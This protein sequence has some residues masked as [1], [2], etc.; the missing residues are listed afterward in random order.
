MVFREIRHHKH[1]QTEQ[2]KVGVLKR[3]HMGGRLGN[4]LFSWAFAHQLPLCEE[5][6]LL[7]SQSIDP[8]LSQLLHKCT[9]VEIG[10]ISPLV[11]FKL[12]L[13]FKLSN[14]F[15]IMKLFISKAFR[16]SCEPDLLNISN[17]KDYCG[18]FQMY[19][20]VKNS[21]EIIF[22]ELMASVQQIDLPTSFLEWQNGRRYQCWHIRRGDYLLPENSGYGLLSLEWYLKHK[23]L[24]MRTV[25][26]TD[27]KASALKLLK[28]DDNYLILGP[29]D[30]NVFQA[31]AIMSKSSH[32]VAANSTLSWW[33]GFLVATQGHSVIYPTS[34][35]EKH[36]DINSPL[37]DL[38][39]G[40][41]D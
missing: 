30:A 11:R 16:V 5:S 41:Y 14:K 2:P 3:I 35:V 38:K 24:N 39:P 21:Q 23:N 22:K 40:V 4:Q 31:L 19:E 25:I 34:E 12:K 26:V 7:I 37:F 32:L 18:F 29:D 1:E 27:D 28:A 8:E 33:G 6:V 10:T 17:S 15:K 9:H 20:Y 36:R 13:Y